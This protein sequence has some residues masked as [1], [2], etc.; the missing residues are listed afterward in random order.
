MALHDAGVG[1]VVELLDPHHGIANGIHL[2]DGLLVWW[3]SA[4]TEVV[5]PAGQTLRAS[6]SGKDP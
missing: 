2:A 1:S 6:R 4:A 5:A 3:T